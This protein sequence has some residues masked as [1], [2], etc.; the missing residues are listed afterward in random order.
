MKKHRNLAT[1][2]LFVVGVS[3]AVVR[4]LLVAGAGGDNDQRAATFVFYGHDTSTYLA[5][6]IALALAAVIVGGAAALRRRAR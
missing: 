2:P 1:V 5:G 6:A 3:L 4:V